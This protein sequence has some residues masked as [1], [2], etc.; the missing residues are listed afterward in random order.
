MSDRIMSGLRRGKQYF[1]SFD[2]F[3]IP[4]KVNLEGQTTYKTLFGAII[5][6]IFAGVMFAQIYLGFDKMINRTDPD[7]SFYKLT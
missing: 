5:T 3:G 1:R 7:Y 4:I 6:A 2:Y